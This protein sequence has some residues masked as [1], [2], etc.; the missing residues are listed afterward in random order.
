MIIRI[1]APDC[2]A[3]QYAGPVQI[4]D[5][6]IWLN[7]IDKIKLIN[8]DSMEEWIYNHNDGFINIE[9]FDIKEDEDWVYFLTNQGVI[10]Y[11]WSNYHF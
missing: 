10:F 7:L 4:T 2:D 6:Y 1:G 9:I 8:L 11:N 5:N 3:G